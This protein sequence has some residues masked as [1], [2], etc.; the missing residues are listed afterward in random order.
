M[1]RKNEKP[2]EGEKGILIDN[3][4]SWVSYD[5]F[6]F[7]AS[8]P[9]ALIFGKIESREK[10]Q[11]VNPFCILIMHFPVFFRVLEDMLKY[12]KSD[13]SDTSPRF[14]FTAKNETITSKV[15]FV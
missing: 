9:G 12:I 15:R 6:H 13:K 5:L 4:V 14:E 8:V 11:F 7:V 2:E 1:E 10:I 3:C